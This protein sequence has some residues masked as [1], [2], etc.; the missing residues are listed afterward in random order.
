MTLSKSKMENKI[1]EVLGKYEDYLNISTSASFRTVKK[2]VGVIRRFLLTTNMEKININ[3]INQFL[4]DNTKNKR[5]NYYKYAFKHFL[6][7]LGRKDLIDK[8]ATMSKKPRKKVFKFIPKETMQKVINS[9]PGIYQKLAFLQLKTG[10]RV[11]EIM[12]LRA[13]NFDFNIDDRMIYIKVGVNKS[14]S[15]RNKEK[16]LY[17]PKKYEHLILRWLNCR[18]FGYVFLPHDYETMS[19]E[20]LHTKLDSLRREY[21]RKLAEAGKW[22]HI[23][24]LSSHYLRHLFA[25]YFLKAGGD[26]VYLNKAFNHSK[27]ETTMEYVSIEDQMVKKTIEAME[28]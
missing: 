26:P 21:D 17:L 13:E 2:Y 15:K 28:D 20:V 7:C 5:C 12:T 16:N 11:T 8:L 24:G 4:Y 22:Y 6:V 14:L 10:A 18:T 9:L 1:S 23:D 19:E 27:M 25:D 3:D